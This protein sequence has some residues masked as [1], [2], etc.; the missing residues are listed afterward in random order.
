MANDS[1]VVMRRTRVK[2]LDTCLMRIVHRDSPLAPSTLLGPRCCSRLAAST[3][4]RP[5]LLG[6]VM[7]IVKMQKKGGRNKKKR[8]KGKKE[9]KALERAYSRSVLRRAQ[10]AGTG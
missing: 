8:E 1:T 3:G 4:S 5:F 9:R 10:T 7:E 6:S 2:L